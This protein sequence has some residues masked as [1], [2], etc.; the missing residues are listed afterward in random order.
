MSLGENNTPSCGGCSIKHNS[1]FAGLSAENLAFIET[2]KTCS[3]C[4]KGAILFKIGSRPSG[5]FCILKGK[6]KVYT[7][8]IDGKQ[9]IIQLAKEGENLGFRTMISGETFKVTAETL[10]DSQICFIPKSHFLLAMEQIPELN[11]NVLKKLSVELNAM[12]KNLTNL[13]QKPVK[14]R[15]AATLIILEDLYR[16]S[17]S[18]ERVTINLTREDLANFVGTATET[19]IRLLNA[20]KKEKLIAI[21]G[22]KISIANHQ[23]LSKLAKIER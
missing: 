23:Q 16:D 13:A 2:S 11:Q 9:Q 17:D 5:V 14:Q 10:E 1:L 19:I 12:T 3:V 22:R 7:L 6:V 21:E 18:F 8:G 15:L 4:P 20:L